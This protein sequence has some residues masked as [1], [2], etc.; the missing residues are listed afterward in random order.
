MKAKAKNISMVFLAALASA[1]AND[2]S[3]DP[4]QRFSNGMCLPMASA[5]SKGDAG[6]DAD[7]PKI[8]TADA[9]PAGEFNRTCTHHSECGCPAPVCAV[10]PGQKQGF[11]TQIC[12]NDPSICPSGF[13]CVDLS[14]VDPSYPPTCLPS[15]LTP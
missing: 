6:A 2:A 10:A 11:C 1:C 13:R 5:S 7:V 14:A 3:C 12:P 8:C 4:D 15:G 9:A